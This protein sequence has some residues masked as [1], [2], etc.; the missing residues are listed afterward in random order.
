MASLAPSIF[1]WSRKRVRTAPVAGQRQPA[2]R[3][4]VLLA[5]AKDSDRQLLQNVL[6]DTAYLLVHTDN[7]QT[8][9]NLAGHIVFPVILYDRLFD[10]VDWRLAVKRLARSW[11]TPSVLLL[12]Q[13][14][15]HGLRDELI[16]SGGFDLLVRPVEFGELFRT[17][18]AAMARFLRLAP[19]AEPA[20]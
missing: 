2:P 14:H 17:V 10:T 4:P 5:S 11:R 7:W 12:S 15:E 18:D 13:D 19:S 1:K 3:T 20:R 16:G 8:T 9:L 6:K